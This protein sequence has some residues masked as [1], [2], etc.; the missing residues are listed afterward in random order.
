MPFSRLL[1]K[2][3]HP[4]LAP[5]ASTDAEN[6][7]SADDPGGQPQRRQFGEPA[8]T[9][10]RP[11]RRKRPSTA[12][13]SV[14]SR[15]TSTPLL[16]PK[17]ENPTPQGGVR[18]MPFPKPLPP[19][20]SVFLTNL[21]IVSPPET[22]DKLA[23]AWEAVKDEPEV[24]DISRELDTVGLYLLPRL[25]SLCNLILAPDDEVDTIQNNTQP[26]LPVITAT[27]AA[28][29]QSGIGK[30]IKDRIDTFS[31][32]M[33]VLMNALDELKAVHPFIGGELIK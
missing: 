33:P 31:E 10:P 23:E 4:N 14:I 13:G 19:D 6:G 26:F 15:Q 30:A 24:V 1:R 27:V 3:S 11:W 9:M 5:P 28:A 17:A 32:G 25:L 12:G 22:Q 8:R 16:I 2:L 7:P 20:P 21:A 29:A 18:R